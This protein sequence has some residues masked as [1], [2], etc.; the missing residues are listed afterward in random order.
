MLVLSRKEG[1]RIVIGR[2]IVI[3]VVKSCGK[4][5]RLGVTAPKGIPINREEV[6]ERLAREDHAT[7]A[8]ASR[9]R[10]P[11]FAEFN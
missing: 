9:D 1:E 11:Y 2:D 4:R 8:D 6:F 10:L 5:V 3:T 7:P